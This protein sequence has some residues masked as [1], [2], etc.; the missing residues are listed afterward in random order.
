[1][2]NAFVWYHEETMV[3]PLASFFAPPELIGG[4]TEQGHEL[5][6]FSVFPYAIVFLYAMLSEVEAFCCLQKLVTM[7]P[8]YGEDG[9]SEDLPTRV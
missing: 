2:V 6:L 9:L 8:A 3:W 7:C 1:M 5:S 4:F